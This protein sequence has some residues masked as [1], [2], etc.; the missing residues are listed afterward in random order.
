MERPG[1]DKRT[2]WQKTKDFF[3]KTYDETEKFTEEDIDA[4]AFFAPVAYIAILFFVPILIKPKSA[5]A[6]YHANQGL[7]LLLTAL[8][9]YVAIFLIGLLLNLV[10][11]WIFTICLYVVCNS[12]FILCIIVGAYNAS[13]GY[14]KELPLMGRWRIIKVR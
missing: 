4:S 11:L 8:V 10:G 9:T 12:F 13:S 2:N 1:V 14:A 7:L 5:F 3:L 6:K